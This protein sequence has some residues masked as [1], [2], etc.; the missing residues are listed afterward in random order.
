MNS[1]ALYIL[2]SA[3]AVC[4][5]SLIS[6]STNSA[7]QTI[8]PEFYTADEMEDISIILNYSDEMLMR[9]AGV[10]NP[11][12]AY[13]IFVSDYSDSQD[14]STFFDSLYVSPLSTIRTIENGS[15]YTETYYISTFK[16]SA[17][18]VLAPKPNS[19]YISFLM[20]LGEKDSVYTEYAELIQSATDFVPSVIWG[21]P[22]TMQ[23]FE[24]PDV[25]TVWAVQFLAVFSRGHQI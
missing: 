19:K 12:E 2:R 21:L 11:A 14:G 20:K 23:N 25:R 16:D 3:L 5:I 17:G 22:N 15:F 7:P 13:R 9:Y 10:D 24:N 8:L 1:K 18:A 6:C 4:C